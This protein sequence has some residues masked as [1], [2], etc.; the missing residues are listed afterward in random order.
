MRSL[1]LLAASAVA[2]SGCMPHTQTARAELS[3]Q[4]KFSII[5]V[6]NFYSYVIDP[7]TESC[8]LRQTGYEF[9][10]AM[11]QVPCEKLKQNVPEAA[12]AITWLPDAKP[13]A[14]VAAPTP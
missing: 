3:G 10:F 4:E 1:L 6:D 14:A 11:V 2:L 12:Q 8:F 5:Q 13:A 7:R 9:N